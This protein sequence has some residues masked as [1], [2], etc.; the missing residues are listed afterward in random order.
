[1]CVDWVSYI[2]EIRLAF[3][4]SLPVG[5]YLS[6]RYNGAKDPFLLL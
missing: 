6:M 5:V 2:L 4:V 1:M 3:E